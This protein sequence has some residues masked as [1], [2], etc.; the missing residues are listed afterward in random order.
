MT[1]VTSVTPP[2]PAKAEIGTLP[3]AQGGSSG[4]EKK[5]DIH[6]APVHCTTVFQNLNLGQDTRANQTRNGRT[7]DGKTTHEH[8]RIH[9]GDRPRTNPS[10][11][12]GASLQRA[13][14]REREREGRRS[15]SATSQ[16]YKYKYLSPPARVC[17]QGIRDTERTALPHVPNYC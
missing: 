8:S 6:T 3:L 12:E 16:V 17:T 15:Q 4:V 5:G 11:R 7:T 10:V 9:V 14:E 2:L 13:R 1:S